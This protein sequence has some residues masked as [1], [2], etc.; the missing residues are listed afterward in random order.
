MTAT[1]GRTAP[2]RATE[3]R[4]VLY[5]EALAMIERS[6]SDERLTVT[7]LSRGIYSSRRQ[8]QRSFAEAGTSVRETLHTIRMRRA[9]EL[10]RESAL[11]VAQI[12]Q[13]V[14][15]RQP[16]QFAKA[17]RRYHGVSPSQWREGGERRLD[18][19]A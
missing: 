15:Y 17:F 4:R 5:E 14:G 3:R 12:G 18:A 2:S 8:V 6:Y 16:A 10:L 9:A 13:R 7:E 19:A 1:I 11:P